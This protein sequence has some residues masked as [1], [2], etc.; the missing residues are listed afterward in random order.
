[1]TQASGSRH[2][3]AY[4]N[5]TTFGTTPT[6]PTM[7]QFRNTGTTLKASK[8][9]FVSE[10]IRND[11]HVV[12]LRHGLK[13]IGGDLNFEYCPGYL[14]DF[15]EKA[16]FGTWSTNVLKAGTTAGY[17]SI[18]RAFAD[19]SEYHQFTGCMVNTMSLN[20]VPN[21]MVKG[22]FGI[23]GKDVT[24]ASTALDSSV[25]AADTDPPFDGFTGSILEGGG[26]A[27]NVTSLTID[28][29]NNLDPSFVIG[30]DTTPNIL[31]GQSIVTGTLTSFFESETLLN[32]FRNE[33]ECSVS[34]TLEGVS[35]WDHTILI[36]RV[37]YT[38]GEVDV[39]SAN[40][41]LLVNMPFHA[42]RDSTEATN[43]KI[44][45]TAV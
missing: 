42:L 37:K 27:N 20:I 45:R 35:G 22:T 40:D 7:L 21:D 28:L 16:L 2:S 23:V 8:D 13:Q 30:A 34:V 36:P 41:G 29:N 32:K 33:T 5:E 31:S 4:V 39:T 26:A 3:V 14:D 19:V 17:F 12:D 11:R 1:M 9:N 24:V 25:T 6:T 15:L 18:E 44:T 43:I 10:E 38:A